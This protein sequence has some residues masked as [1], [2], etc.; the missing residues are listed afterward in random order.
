MKYNYYDNSSI[1]LVHNKYD[2]MQ[3]P[4]SYCKP[5]YIFVVFTYPNFVVL[6]CLGS[7]V[8]VHALTAICV[9]PGMW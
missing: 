6:K 3:A 7:V 4:A 9:P 1:S 2:A 8:F 5:G